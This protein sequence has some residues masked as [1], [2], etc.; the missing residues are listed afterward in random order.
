MGNDIMTRTEL[1]NALAALEACNSRHHDD[2]QF[3]YGYHA[4]LLDVG[5]AFGLRR[6]V[7]AVLVEAGRNMELWPIEASEA[8]GL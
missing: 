8:G 5:R 2:P 1:A 4:A 7:G 6:D 3:I